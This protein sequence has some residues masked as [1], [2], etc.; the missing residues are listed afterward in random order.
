M[1][2]IIALLLVFV[3]SFSL[4]ACSE[5][6]VASQNLHKEIEEFR[7]PRSIVA[8][9]G[10]TDSVLL[11]VIGYCSIETD[12]SMA[13]GTVEITCKVGESQYTKDFVYLSDNVTF[14][15]EQLE[16]A[17]VSGYRRKII[18]KPTQVIPAIEVIWD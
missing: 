17:T 3:L 14:V 13:K 5:A 9:N 10:I 11:Q 18:W 1:K 4:V 2:K 8:L 15:V 12:S 16:P 6:D 7:V